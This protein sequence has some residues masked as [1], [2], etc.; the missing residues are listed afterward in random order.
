MHG[1]YDGEGSYPI[2]Q[3]DMSSNGPTPA[4]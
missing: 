2:L 4:V 3:D 1:T